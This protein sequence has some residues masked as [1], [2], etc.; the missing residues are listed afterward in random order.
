[1]SK[2][3]NYRPNGPYYEAKEFWRRLGLD[4]IRPWRL[5][6]FNPFQWRLFWFSVEE[7]FPY[8]I[9]ITIQRKDEKNNSKQS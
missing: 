8:T 3:Y 2:T 6:G 4:V 5:F 9:T 7:M 1:M